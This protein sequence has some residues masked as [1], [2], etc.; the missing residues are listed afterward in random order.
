MQNNLSV[1]RTSL[2]STTNV[3]ETLKWKRE[4][5]V[6]DKKPLAESIADYI[7][8]SID[9]LDMQLEYFKEIKA[10]IAQ[11]EKKIKEQK[12][13]VLEGSAAFL[14]D[15]GV[16]K[17]EG[18]IVSSITV[19]KAKPATT[20]KVFKVIEHK[21][22]VEKYLVSAGLAVYEEVE[23]SGAKAK[24]R[25]NKRKIAPAEVVETQ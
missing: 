23:V 17:L 2:S 7:A 4:Q 16:D 18:G 19:T 6:E 22:E 10:E 9:E 14:I 20:K 5:L 15:A 1:K 13:A 21:K 24:I 8:L 11:R 12:A 3:I 25:V